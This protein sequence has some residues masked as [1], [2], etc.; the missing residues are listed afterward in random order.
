[1]VPLLFFLLFIFYSV[2]TALPGIEQEKEG[3]DMSGNKLKTATF[4][5]GCFWCMQ[6]PFDELEGVVETYVGYTGGHAE[7]P[8][9]EEVSA[10]MTGHAESIEVIFDPSRISYA[11]LLD[12]FWRNIDPTTPDRQFV[13]VGNQYRAAIFYHDDEQK[14]LAEESKAKLDTSGRFD[15]PIVTEITPAATFY[16]AEKYHQKYYEKNPIRYKFYRYRSGRD[17]FLEKVWGSK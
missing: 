9:Y 6:R 16:R 1:M 4:A 10:G 5:G 3:P 2:L 12:V 15:K 8:T 14:Q 7:N 11:D 17:Q 13:D